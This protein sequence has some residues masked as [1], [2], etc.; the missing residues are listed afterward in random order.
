MKPAASRLSPVAPL[1]AL[2]FGA[3]AAH[4]ELRL[5]AVFS[6]HMVL[7]QGRDVPVW[8][9][10]NDGDV[11]TVS[12]QNRT[13]TATAAGGRWETSLKPLKAGGPFTFTVSTAG[14]ALELTNVLVGEVWVCS[15]QSNMEWP[16][17]RAFEPETEIAS[18]TNTRI[19]LFKPSHAAPDAPADDVEATWVE[20]SPEQVR[21]FSAVGYYFGRDIQAARKVPVGLIGTH[22]GGSPA[23]A[24]TPIEKL[25]ANPRYQRE[26]LDTHTAAWSEYEAKAEEHRKAKATAEAEGKEFSGRAPRAPWKPASLYNGMIAPLQPFAIRGAIWYQGESNAGRAHQYRDLFVDMIQ[27]W[28]D[29]WGQGDFPFLCVQLAPYKAIQDQPGESDWAEL[30]EAQWLTTRRLP[31]V[32]MVV[33]TDVGDPK[34]IHPRKKEPV[35]ERLALAARAIAYGEKV[36]YSGPEYRRM[37]VKGNTVILEFDHAKQ[38]LELR[39][40]KLTGFAI[41]GEDRQWVWADAV[42]DGKRVVVSSP[43]VSAPVAVRFGWADCPVVNLW[44]WEGLP[45]VPFRTDDFPMVTAPH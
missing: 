33:I 23:E 12:I 22:W 9:Q 28:R 35:G 20:C 27:S 21:R 36:P 4:A 10:A 3:V 2:L 15:G 6:H 7:Q 5:P 34:D 37:K 26:I 1:I 45:A 8:G 16:M 42:I 17:D 40:D 18:A 30:R 41:C 24:W 32:G 19:R 39:G 13:A 25:Q 11:V 31:K 14:Q 44:S 38:G 43:Q 29:T